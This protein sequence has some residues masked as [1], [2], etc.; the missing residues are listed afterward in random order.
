MIVI[1][2]NWIWTPI[3]YFKRDYL[4]SID[5]IEDAT[6]IE[7]SNDAIQLLSKN[8]AKILHP[9]YDDQNQEKFTQDDTNMIKENI[10]ITLLSDNQLED[11]INKNQ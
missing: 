4:I 7:K 8:V 5:T 10:L 2:I 3:F 1:N 11:Q 9:E 6:F